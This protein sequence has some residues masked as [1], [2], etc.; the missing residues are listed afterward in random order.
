ML[1]T[2]AAMYPYLSEEE[3]KVVKSL[4]SKME[5]TLQRRDKL[6]DQYV[7]IEN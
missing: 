7:N 6:F 3:V 4:E 1:R 2:R 5:K